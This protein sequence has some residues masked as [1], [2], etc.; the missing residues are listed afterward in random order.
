MSLAQNL[1]SAFGKVFRI[2]PLGSNSA[3][4]KY[5]IPAANPFRNTSGALPEIYACGVRNPQRIGWDPKTGRMFLADIGQ[6]IVEEI[7]P[8]TAGA[9]LGW[10]VWEGSF[11]FIGRQA[12]SVESPRSDPTMTYPIAEWGHTDPLLSSRSAATGVVVYRG[13]EIPQ[14]ANLLVFAD[15]PGGEI[16]FVSADKLPA[17]GQDPIRRI[18]LSHNGAT[19][20]LLELIQEKNKSQNK[21]PATR[22]DLR[23]GLGP[24]DQVFLLNKGDGTIRLLVR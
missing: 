8:V 20:T 11:R 16:F 2:D 13:R 23:F 17:G 19:K 3:N 5:G 14:L 21:T 6:N 12:V 7:S 24:D 10:N 18:L 22:S 9:N 4:K 15:M 1:G